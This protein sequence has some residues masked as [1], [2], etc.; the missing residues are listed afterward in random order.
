MRHSGFK[1]GLPI[2]LTAL[3]ASRINEERSHPNRTIETAGM[4]V[5]RLNSE[6]K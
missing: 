5:L 1:G 2:D 3:A 6:D 4:Q